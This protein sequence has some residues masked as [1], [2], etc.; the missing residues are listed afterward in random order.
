MYKNGFSALRIVEEIDKETTYSQ[1]DPMALLRN[2]KI[3][4]FVEKDDTAVITENEDRD[5][6]SMPLNSTTSKKRQTFLLSATLSK[7]LA[8]LSDFT[9]KDHIYIDALEESSH[10]NP[11]FLVIPSTVKQTFIVTHVKHRLFTLSALLLAQT[12]KSCK[13]FLFMGTSTMVDYHFELFTRLLVKM[14]KNRGK[15]KSGDVVLLDT[16]EE[17]DDDEEETVM[18][19]DFFKLHGSMEQSSRK[20]VFTKFKAS[21]AGILICTVSDFFF[22]LFSIVSW[23]IYQIFMKVMNL[24]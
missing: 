19:I 6:D 10:L 21:K 22:G 5:S 24:S 8:E 3:K 4:K 16:M 23:E 15:L 12:K 7:G 17:D 18:D 11:E 20:E 14:P 1:Y 2:N 9:M 13:V